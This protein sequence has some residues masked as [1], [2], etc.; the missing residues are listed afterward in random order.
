MPLDKEV[1]RMC[2][3]LEAMRAAAVR[4][5]PLRLVMLPRAPLSQ[6]IPGSHSGHDVVWPDQLAM[7]THEKWYCPVSFMQPAPW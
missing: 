3:L 7:G 4:T 2:A 1:S 6:G 5:T